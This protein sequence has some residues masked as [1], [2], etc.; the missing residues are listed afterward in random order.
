MDS[1]NSPPTLADWQ[2]NIAQCQSIIDETDAFLRKH[3]P[4]IRRLHSLVT[5]NPAA[6][7]ELSDV[8]MLTLLQPVAFWLQHITH[9]RLQEAAKASAADLN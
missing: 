8:E 5:A 1:E 2:R 9:A 7:A 4:G 3:E 6:A